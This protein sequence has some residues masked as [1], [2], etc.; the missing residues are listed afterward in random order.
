MGKRWHEFE[1]KQGGIYG[2]NLKV[3]NVIRIQLYFFKI[4]EIFKNNKN[5]PTILL[6]CNADILNILCEIKLIT[7]FKTY[8]ILSH[9]F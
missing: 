2:K 5:I 1:K 6:C 8:L 4:K 7:H 3:T 9:L